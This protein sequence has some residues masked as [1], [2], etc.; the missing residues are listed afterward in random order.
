MTKLI[1][2][3]EYVGPTFHLM[4]IHLKR[5]WMAHDLYEHE[6]TIAAVGPRGQAALAADGFRLLG[7][8][9]YARE[10]GEG[11]ARDENMIAKFQTACCYV[12]VS[13]KC[14]S[15]SNSTASGTAHLVT[16]LAL[17]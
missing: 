10:V 14:I 1:C 7:V 3:G 6:H 15:R 17:F 11:A 4:E 8:D 9:D 13:R 16:V 2:L 5:N 12:H